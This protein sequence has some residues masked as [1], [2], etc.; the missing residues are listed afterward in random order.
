MLSAKKSPLFAAGTDT[1]QKAIEEAIAYAR[2]FLGQGAPADYIPELAKANPDHLAVCVETLEHG[3]CCCG[4]CHQKFTLQSISKVI[5]LILAVEDHGV[6]AVFEKVGMEPT[7]DPFNSILRL[8]SASSKPS[9]PMINAGAIV[10]TS[11]IKGSS[12][13]ERFQRLLDLLRRLCGNDALGYSEETFRSEQNTGDKNRALSYMMR[14]GGI[15]SGDVEEHL[16][17]YFKFCSAL[18]DCT[19]IARL[20]AVLAND[21]YSPQTGECMVPLEVLKIVRSLMVTCGMY[22]FSGEFAALVGLPSKSGVGGGIVSVVPNTMGIGVFGPALDG[23]GNSVGGV[24]ILE[25][26]SRNYGLSIF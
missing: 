11:M 21:G 8:E 12:G 13:E 18:V 6:D 14:S 3:L 24:K 20:G 15:I 9:N 23:R 7:G 5:S 4:D 2:P 22:D 10:V 25:Y 16:E 17:C 26:L 19:D 1:I